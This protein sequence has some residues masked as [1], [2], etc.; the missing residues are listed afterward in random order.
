MH[1]KGYQDTRSDKKFSI[2]NTVLNLFVQYSRFIYSLKSI[3]NSN[4]YSPASK[5]KMRLKSKCS[6]KKGIS[7]I[8]WDMKYDDSFCAA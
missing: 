6:Q 2:N 7:S 3:R 4:M 8:S 5:V 1:K